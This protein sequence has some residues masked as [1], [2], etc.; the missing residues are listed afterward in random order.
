MD[1]AAWGTVFSVTDITFQGDGNWHKI[2]YSFTPSVVAGEPDFDHL[3]LSLS[4][5]RNVSTIY[6][7]H[8]VLTTDMVDEAHEA[9]HYYVSKV[10]DDANVG[11]EDSPFLTIAKAASMVKA[12]DVVTIKEGTY[13]ETLAPAS[14][15]TAEKPI[16]F[17]AAAGEKVILTAMQEVGDWELD[18]GSVYKT[19]VD[20]SLGQ[21]NFVMNGADACQLARWPNKTDKDPFVLNSLRNTGGTDGSVVS[22]ARLEYSP[23]IQNIDW[24]DG[25]YLF[26][27]CDKGG[28]GWTSWRAWITSNN[29]N[30]VTFDLPDSPTWLGGQHPPAWLG[31]F[32]LVGAKGALDYANEWFLD[33][34]SHTLYLQTPD[35]QMPEDGQIQVRKR[36]VCINLNN[37]SYIHIK[38]MAVFGGSIEM[39]GNANY[40]LVSGVSSYYG[41]FTEGV[42]NNFSANEQSV[43]IE[44][45]YNTI[46]K[47]E[48]AFGAAS[49]IRDAGAYTTISNCFIHDFDF[50]GNYDCPVNLRGGSYTT[51]KNNTIYN[52]G[53]DCIQMFNANSE[54]AYNNI[55]RSNLIADDCGLLYTVGGPHYAEIHHNWFHDTESR[56]DLHK[57]AGIYLDNDASS[58]SVHHNAVWN[59]EWNSIQINWNGTDIDIFNNTL[60][61]GEG[62]MGAWHM[63]GTAFSNVRVWN[64]LANNNEWEEQS[65]QQNNLSVTVGNPFTDL[66][67]GDLTLKAS[68]SAIDYGRVIDGITDGF[69]GDNPDVGA[70]EY[71]TTAWTAGTNWLL[72]EGPNKLGCYGL[73]GDDCSVNPDLS[74]LDTDG[75]GV[76]DDIDQCPNTEP[77]KEVDD[78]GCV[79]VSV[80]SLEEVNMNIYPN[81]VKGNFLIIETGDLTGGNFLY[82]IYSP[83]GSKVKS[84]WVDQYSAQ[85]RLDIS[86]LPAGCFFMVFKNAHLQVGTK[87]IKL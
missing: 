71:G 27:Y 19:T 1:G 14:S 54:I 10:G 16:V 39:T 38:N 59:T 84:G 77:G 22:N 5:A 61:E 64:N 15:G 34:A 21:N 79:N 35:G 20:W 7:D 56:G 26:F 57:A 25:G 2:A 47:C 48:I 76:S 72:A 82:E 81:P 66:D 75:D 42:I 3:A 17:Q 45:S 36:K 40:N 55:Y 86:G 9:Q 31:D 51:L 83:S 8:F 4:L 44:G 63:D 68:S 65:D 13:E 46:D 78:K 30:S 33:E 6:L 69:V 62:A 18:E 87:F 11:S 58:F 52:A 32:F 50:L 74:E 73:P 53:R 29:T 41:N 85:V 28:S 12:G 80:G 60:W 49:G 24:S 37:K 70:Y 43:N 23:G 67:A